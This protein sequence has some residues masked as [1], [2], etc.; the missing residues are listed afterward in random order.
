VHTG[1]HYDPEMSDRF[2][3]EYK[4]RPPDVNLGVGK[5][6][7]D[8]QMG[9]MIDRIGAYLSTEQPQAVLVFGDT[10]S[11]AAGAIA[12]SLYNVP[13]A[14]VEAGLRSYDLKMAEEK[15]RVIADHLSQWLFCPTSEAVNNLKVEGFRK[16]IFPVGDVMTETFRLPKAFP[17]KLFRGQG[18]KPPVKNEYYFVTLHRAEAVDDPEKLDKLLEM[19]ILLDKPIVFPVHPRTRKNVKRFGLWKT[20]QSLADALILP[21]VNHRAVL[22]LI[23]HSASVITDSGGVQKEAYWAGVRCLTCRTV[24]E[25]RLLVKAGQNILI[26]FSLA[27]LRRAL[28]TPFTWRRAN[29]R[30]F[31]RKDASQ[32]IINHLKRDLA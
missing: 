8:R 24:T 14:H 5:G 18:F 28:K 6:R 32:S 12:G 13:V 7:V 23:A 17:A 22:S 16:Q 1:Q 25:W 9:Q 10:T 30:I 11:T 31:A 26:G 3:A 20:L 15:N 2:F 27:K 21:P 29:D 19:L 4:L